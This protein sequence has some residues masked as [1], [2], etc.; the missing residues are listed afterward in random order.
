[1][2]TRNSQKKSPCFKS[3]ELKR[4]FIGHLGQQIF[5]ICEL[6][7]EMV[8]YTGWGVRLFCRSEYLATETSCRNILLY[9][10]NQ[11][12]THLWLWHTWRNFYFVT[13]P[14]GLWQGPNFV[15]WHSQYNSFSCVLSRIH[16]G[17]TLLE[18]HWAFS[19]NKE[20]ISAKFTLFRTNVTNYPFVR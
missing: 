5:R 8:Q 14:G 20:W 7:V 6:M 19:A 13:L 9:N 11:S 15:R 17:S 4:K 12:V 2:V 10:F 3:L 1:M 16:G 18:P